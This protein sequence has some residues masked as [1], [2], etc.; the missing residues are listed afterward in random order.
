MVFTVSDGLQGGRSA[1]SSLSP[2]FLGVQQVQPCAPQLC[3]ICILPQAQPGCRGRRRLE[4]REIPSC[5]HEGR[6]SRL[7]ITIIDHCNAVLQAVPTAEKL[8]KEQLQ[9][10]A[11]RIASQV[12]DGAQR[13][14]Q[15]VL[16]PEAQKLAEQVKSRSDSVSKYCLLGGW[17][18]RVT[19]EVLLPEAQ[20]LADS[21]SLRLSIEYAAEPVV[22]SSAKTDDL[23]RLNACFVCEGVATAGLPF[24][25]KLSV[26]S[27]S[28]HYLHH[29]C[30]Q[31]QPTAD[32]VKGEII[33]PLADKVKAEV[34]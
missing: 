21:V 17:A 3:T 15:E 18:Q 22:K 31:A 26:C 33:Q 23:A 28:V 13:V 6:V 34:G 2:S 20:K 24:T 11:D 9:P 12:E 30:T 16:L 25:I 27:A 19:Q 5:T 1:C 10:G 14:T 32:E 8:T 29:C 4:P 7:S